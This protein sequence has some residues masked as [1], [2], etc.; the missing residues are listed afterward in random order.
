MAGEKNIA[1]TVPQESKLC[2]DFNIGK[3]TNNFK[4]REQLLKLLNCMAIADPTVY[5]KSY[6]DGMEWM[7]NK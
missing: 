4:G 6:F 7:N 1:M 2:L 5:A 3:D